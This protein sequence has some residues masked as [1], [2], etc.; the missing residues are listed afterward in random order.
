[1]KWRTLAVLALVLAAGWAFAQ[2]G[3]GEKKGK[4]PQLRELAGTVMDRADGPLTSAIVYLKNSK[5][6]VVKTYITDKDGKYRFPALAQNVDYQVYAEFQGKKSDTKTLSSFD[7]RT[8]INI[9]LKVDTS[10]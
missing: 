9:N 4:Q 3:L 7:S 5:T 8:Q 2:F 1:M 10:R 6:L